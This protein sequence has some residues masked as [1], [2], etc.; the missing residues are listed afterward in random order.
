MVGGR[1]NAAVFIHTKRIVV[2]AAAHGASRKPR[3]ELQPLHG[4]DTEDRRRKTVFDSVKHRVADA[5]RESDRRALDHATDGIPRMCGRQDR[6]LHLAAKRIVE[7]R[8]LLLRN[9]VK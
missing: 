8:E 2:F 7:N 1:G 6:L 5:G 3:A 4:G 9:P